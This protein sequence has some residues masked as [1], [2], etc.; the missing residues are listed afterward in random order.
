V[1][2]YVLWLMHVGVLKTDEVKIEIDV[3]IFLASTRL[4]RFEFTYDAIHLC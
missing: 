4:R 2:V 3:R 1:L